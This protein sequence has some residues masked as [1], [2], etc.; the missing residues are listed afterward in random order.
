MR[1]QAADSNFDQSLPA[2]PV[3]IV[4]L[5]DERVERRVVELLVHEAVAP[6]ET[7]R[8]E[9]GAQSDAEHD[10]V[11]ISFLRPGRRNSYGRAK[12]GFSMFQ[13]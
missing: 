9:L 3:A 12:I 11:E 2:L 7:R 13:S 5:L 8:P 4:K 10:V 1:D 6:A